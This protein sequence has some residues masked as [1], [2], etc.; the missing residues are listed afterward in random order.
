M[1][2]AID[3]EDPFLSYHTNGIELWVHFVRRRSLANFEIL[4][5]FEEDYPNILKYYTLPDH[6]VALPPKPNVLSRQWFKNM[7]PAMPPVLQ[8]R[9]PFNIVRSLLYA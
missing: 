1:T 9:F 5:T 7:T 4:S 2:S 6:P 3:I 8:F